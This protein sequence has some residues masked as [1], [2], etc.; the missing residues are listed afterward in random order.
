MTLPVADHTSRIHDAVTACA[1]R[2]CDAPATAMVLM[3]GPSEDP[4]SYRPHC[5]EHEREYA[6][7]FGPRDIHPLP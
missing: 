7:R 2:N 5:F 6:D 3:A 4:T 1:R